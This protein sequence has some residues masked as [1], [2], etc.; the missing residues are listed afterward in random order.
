M[1]P[2]PGAPCQ[3]TLRR[4]ARLGARR[5]LLRDPLTHITGPLVG[6]LKGGGGREEGGE[7]EAGKEGLLTAT[8]PAPQRPGPTARFGCPSPALGVPPSY[9]HTCL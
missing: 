4:E 9:T 6:G 5:V 3:D 7:R 2:R 8:G 1:A